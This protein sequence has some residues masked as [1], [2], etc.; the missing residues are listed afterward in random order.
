MIKT[1][2]QSRKLVEINIPLTRKKGL[3]NLFKKLVRKRDIPKVRLE[4]VIFKYGGWSIYKEFRVIDKIQYGEYLC[5]YTFRNGKRLKK[6][7]GK[8]RENKVEKGK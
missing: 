7:I 6:Y 3:K 2:T 5:A 1:L 8:V 4:R